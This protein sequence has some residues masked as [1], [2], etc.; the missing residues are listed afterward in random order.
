MSSFACA[1]LTVSPN[2]WIVYAKAYSDTF[3]KSWYFPI[4]LRR[5][6]YS[7]CLARHWALKATGSGA[8]ALQASATAPTS[9]TV[10]YISN[11]TPRTLSLAMCGLSSICC[12]GPWRPSSP[13][14]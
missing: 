3:Q 5:K 11:A 2:R 14:V 9:T 7:S 8:I 10:P 13:P 4:A 12:A 6:E 1:G